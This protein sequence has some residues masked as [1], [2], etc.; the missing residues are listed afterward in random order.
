MIQ[1]FI[2]LFLGCRHQRY[3]F[4]QT[5]RTTHITTVTCAD[6]GRQ[7]GYDWAAMK[8]LGPVDAGEV[9]VPCPVEEARRA[10]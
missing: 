6:C 9:L 8:R 2:N 10:L 7:F 5:D 4:P 1:S 3:H